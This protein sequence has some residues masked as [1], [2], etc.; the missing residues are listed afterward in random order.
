MC[1]RFTL[2]TP[3]HTVADAF[4]LAPTVADD[5]WP[6][7]YNVAPT[8]QI[9]A[10]RTRPGK[11]ERELTSLHWGLIPSWADDPA[12]GNRMIN[13]RGETVAEKPAYR[14][15][16]R[17]RR[18]LIAADGFYEW[19]QGSK[20]KQPF[21]IHLKSERPFAFAGLWERWRRGEQTIESCTIVT[22]T[23][24]ELLRPLHERM[25]V[26]VRPEDYAT[27]LNVD[28]QDPE[29]L[30]PLLAPYSAEA[31][32]L[33]PVSSAVNSARRDDAACLERAAPVKTQGTLF[34]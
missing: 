18:C 31:M 30:E 16:F 11:R 13:A 27:W 29:Q 12:I 2:K 22:T 26:I 1:G 5:A 32:A 24:N 3:L 9:A 34:D 20:P 25:P 19:K 10:I 21:Y 6:A 33:Y 28:L 4:D 7:R 15:A 23:A 17:Q 14:E 8:Q